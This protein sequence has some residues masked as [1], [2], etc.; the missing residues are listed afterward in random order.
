MLYSGCKYN[1]IGQKKVTVS[2]LEIASVLLMT[3]VSNWV[4]GLPATKADLK[5]PTVEGV[6]E[7]GKNEKV[8]PLEELKQAKESDFKVPNGGQAPGL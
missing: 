2:S 4:S 5:N 6:S 1:P 7:E 8:I 3:I